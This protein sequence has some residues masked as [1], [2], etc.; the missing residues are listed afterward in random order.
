VNGYYQNML[1]RTN[2]WFALNFFVSMVTFAFIINWLWYLNEGSILTGFFCHTMVNLQG[3][4]QMGQ[5]AKCIQ[6]LL[7]I[8]IVVIIVSVN[9]KIFFK[10]FPPQIGRFG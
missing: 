4:L 2:P 8:G 7:W 10:P 9:K 5:I 6:T 3:L 1:L